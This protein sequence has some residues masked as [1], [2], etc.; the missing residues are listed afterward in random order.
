V[1]GLILLA[2]I[3]AAGAVGWLVYRGWREARARRQAAEGGGRPGEPRRRAG[4]GLLAWGRG[5]RP[6]RGPAAPSHRPVVDTEFSSETFVPPEAARPPLRRIAVPGWEHPVPWSYGE[7]RLVALTR[8]P[9]WI[10]AYWELTDEVHR[11]A[12]ERVGREAWFHARPVI[13]VYDVTGGGRY[14]VAVDEGARNWYLNVG[15]PD[16]T[17]YLELGRITEAGEFVMLARSNT[18][19]TPRDA[20]SGVIDWRWPPFYQL[21]GES[22]W[23]EGMPG[24]PGGL[25]ASPGMP[26]APGAPGSPSGG[27]STS[28][29]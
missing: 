15:Q 10:F 29:D 5:D 20:P 24:S 28:G 4:R 7:T 9:Y 26:S 22:F 11:A 8:D 13:R 6:G 2:A 23:P 1:S 3:L 12:E 25:P 21:Y 14:D 27:W 19:H 18:V 16:R 17:W